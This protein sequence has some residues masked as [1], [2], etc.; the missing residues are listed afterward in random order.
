MTDVYLNNKLAG[1]VE[2]PAEFVQQIINE[3]RRGVVDTNV[4]LSYFKE[5]DEIYVENSRG[6]AR[7]PLI[8]VKDGKPLLT[9]KHMQQLQKNEIGW[10]DLVKQG[11][12]E[13]LDALEEENSYVAFFEGGPDKGT[14]SS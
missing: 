1:T 3:R 2:N 5:Q 12:I 11:V 7:R 14:H 13:Y 8:V 6:R 9:D 4:N 10:S